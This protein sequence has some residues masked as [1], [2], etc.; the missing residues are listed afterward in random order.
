MREREGQYVPRRVG[1]EARSCACMCEGARVRVCCRASPD[2]RPKPM[3]VLL[4][5]RKAKALTELKEPEVG[6]HRHA[7]I[8]LTLKEQLRHPGLHISEYFHEE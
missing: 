3:D 4:L 1:E 2:V 7:H 8:A 6:T 5:V